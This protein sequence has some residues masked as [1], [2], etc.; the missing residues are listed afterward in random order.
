MF[1]VNSVISMCEVYFQE[2]LWLFRIFPYKLILA[3]TGHAEVTSE[4]RRKVGVGRRGSDM[5]P[6]KIFPTE[7]TA[8]AKAL[9]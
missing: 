8:S 4:Q 1:Q 3:P 7:E 2:S 5:Y 6:G 9:R